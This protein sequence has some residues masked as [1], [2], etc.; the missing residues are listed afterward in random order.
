MAS[1][2]TGR[3]ERERVKTEPV[4]QFK[5]KIETHFR[6]RY[7]DGEIKQGAKHVVKSCRNRH[8]GSDRV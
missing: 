6:S 2:D 3:E 8:R 1:V 7:S 4:N 5:L